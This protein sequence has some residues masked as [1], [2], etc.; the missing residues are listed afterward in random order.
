M[1]KLSAVTGITTLPRVTY[2]MG[3]G[4]VLPLPPPAASCSHTGLWSTLLAWPGCCHSPHVTCAAP[5]PLSGVETQ[6]SVQMS[7][8][9]RS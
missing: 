4:A 2:R 1:A 3:E 7:D 6:P 8:G 9:R 5:H